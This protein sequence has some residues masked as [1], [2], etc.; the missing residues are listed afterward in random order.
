MLGAITALGD[1]LHPV[2]ES[3]GIA[4]RLA[5]DHSG[6]AGFLQHARVVHPLGAVLLA[7]FL[8]YL[9]STLPE[10]FPGREVRLGS[11]AVLSLVLAQVA[12]G[13]VNI[14]LSAPGWMQVVHLA[15]ATLLWVALVLLS[16]AV[17]AARSG[18]QV[19]SPAWT[20]PS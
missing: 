2:V 5:A 20:P 12:A 1:T 8:L 6:T 15:L 19:G 13:V 14:V 4:A 3:Q 16:T 9:V 11:L 7:A 17:L 10:R 18:S